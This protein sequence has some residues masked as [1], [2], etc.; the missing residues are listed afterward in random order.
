MPVMLPAATR[1]RMVE[2]RTCRY[3]CSIG[4]GKV[5]A[6]NPLFQICAYR[7]WGPLPAGGESSRPA[8]SLRSPKDGIAEGKSFIADP[9]GGACV[10][11]SP[12]G[13]H[14]RATCFSTDL[15][16][17]VGHLAALREARDPR[18]TEEHRY[19]HQYDLEDRRNSWP[20]LFGPG[21]ACDLYL[22]RFLRSTTATVRNRA[23]AR[24]APNAALS[25]GRFDPE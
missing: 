13:R 16:S 7:D 18:I 14:Q 10:E 19:S 6:G 15:K 8:T 9:L 1:L 22:L 17:T 11:T 5:R 3:S 4:A 25:W 2:S 21:S 24:A 12:S 20:G 23:V